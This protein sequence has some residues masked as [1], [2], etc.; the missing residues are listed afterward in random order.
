MALADN[1]CPSGLKARDLL[2]RR[3][4]KIDDRPLT[5]RAAVDAFKAQHNVATTPQ[6]FIDDVQI[7]GYEALQNHFGLPKATDADTTYQPVIMLFSVAALLAVAITWLVLNTLFTGQTIAWFIAVAMVLL[8]LQKLQNIETFASLFLTYDL[9]AQR[10][11]AYGYIYPYIETTAGLLMLA[12]VLP[13]LSAPV[14]LAVSGIGAVSVFKAVY[15]DKRTL[16]C[17]CLSDNRVPLGAVSLLENVM[18]LGM[19]VWM[20]AGT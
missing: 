16:K 12:G 17:A 19:A 10:W 14:V 7:A 6:I 20:L 11:G 8:G 18:M 5:T 3:G 1:I 9:L 15:V 13:W 2:R 4:Y